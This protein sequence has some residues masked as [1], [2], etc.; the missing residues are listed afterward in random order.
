MGCRVDLRRAHPARREDRPIDLLRR[1]RSRS[2]TADRVGREVEADHPDHVADAPEGAR[3]PEAL[4]AVASR[5]AR[6]RPL[7]GRTPH[8]RA[9]DRRCRPRETEASRGCG[10]AGDQA[11]RPRRPALRPVPHEPAL[12][13]R[14]HLRLDVVRMG[15][16]RVRVRR[17]LPPHHRVE[18]GDLDDNSARA[19]LP[20]HGSV[21]PPPRRRHR[22]RRAHAPHRRRQR[23]RIQLV[24]ATP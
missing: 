1:E 16:R 5:R 21:H 14:L 23:R 7:H 17:A 24:V 12:G 4:A 10:S 9:R 20:R 8:A 13:R 18:S 6:H 3:G 2:V 22:V 15:L 11:R 19:R